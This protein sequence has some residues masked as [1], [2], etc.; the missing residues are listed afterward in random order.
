[1]FPDNL[2]ITKPKVSLLKTLVSLADYDYLDK[3]FSVY[4]CQQKHILLAKYNTTVYVAACVHLA[5]SLIVLLWLI[6][7]DVTQSRGR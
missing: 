2:V 6:Q 3:P 7:T 1:M 4:L 5:K